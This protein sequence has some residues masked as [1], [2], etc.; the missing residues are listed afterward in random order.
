MH[1]SIRPTGSHGHGPKR[2]LE[3]LTS[4]MGV[5]VPEGPVASVAAG[6]LA[7]F[8]AVPTK[9]GMDLGEVEDFV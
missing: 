9:V 4:K 5:V 7:A 2:D 6:M 1:T 8:A 3:A